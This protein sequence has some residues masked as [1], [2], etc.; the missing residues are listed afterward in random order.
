MSG[1]VHYQRS[2]SVG[3]EFERRRFTASEVLR[4]VE[5]GVIGPDEH[6]ELLEGEL[7]VVTPQ[8][9]PHASR[10]MTF[11]E[12]LSELYRGVGSLRIQLPLDAAP[13]GLPEP[14]LAL[15]RGAGSDYRTRHPSG[16]D[17][18]LVV[19]IARTSQKLDRAKARTYARMGV[20]V[21]W[22]V[23]L[24]AGALEVR[25]APRGDG[26]YART[27]IFGPDDLVELPALARTMRVAE[28]FG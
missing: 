4:M 15:V 20:S 14:D 12:L 11:Q 24:A 17:V 23:D 26:R 19:E 9:P 6:V 21:Y 25:T 16:A 22:I 28:L 10:I 18:I 7:V 8:G 3:S 2:M 13:D 27:E 5:L 1:D